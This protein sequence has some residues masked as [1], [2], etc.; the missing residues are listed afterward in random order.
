LISIFLGIISGFIPA[1]KA[2]KM[3]PVVAINH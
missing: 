3:D 2:S 1:N